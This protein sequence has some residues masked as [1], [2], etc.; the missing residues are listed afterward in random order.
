MTVVVNSA[1]KLQYGYGHL[2]SSIMLP[3]LRRT[4]LLWS[5][6]SLVAISGSAMPRHHDSYP[7][8]DCLL[9]HACGYTLICSVM[10]NFGSV[11]TS[12]SDQAAQV[13]GSTAQLASSKLTSSYFGP[14]IG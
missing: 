10:S 1:Y 8:I 14:E 12:C 6:I 4:V 5:L 9:F 7:P 11:E 13:E 3:R 2:L